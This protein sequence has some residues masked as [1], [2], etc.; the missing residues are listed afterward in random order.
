MSFE[1]EVQGLNPLLKALEHWPDIVQPILRDAASA[2]LIS[3]VPFLADYPAP[4]EH[5]TYERTGDLGRLW[6][7]ARPEFAPQSSG[8]EAS[9]GN[10]RPGGEFVQGERQAKVHQGRWPT[11]EQVVTTHQAEI[12]AYFEHALQEIVAKIN[13]SVGG[14]Q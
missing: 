8:F 12:E 6:T 10:N 14:T 2:A 13:E 11:V 9:I 4:P 5:S 1:V 7:I 3:L